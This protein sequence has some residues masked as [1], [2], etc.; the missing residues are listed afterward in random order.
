MTR[1]GRHN[2][3]MT[4]ANARCKGPPAF[5]YL[6][7]SFV[8]DEYLILLL[9]VLLL[10]LLLPIYL[11]TYSIFLI[12]FRS[13][14]NG[15]TITATAVAPLLLLHAVVLL[16]PIIYSEASLRVN[17]RPRFL[18]F[19]VRTWPLASQLTSKQ[20]HPRPRLLPVSFSLLELF[21]HFVSPTTTTTS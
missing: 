16:L 7:I 10:L 4:D 19:L 11:F 20:E 8:C 17:Y 18:G 6:F 1:D 13:F 3:T 12:S 15:S 9:L 5:K 21:L 14:G 2:D